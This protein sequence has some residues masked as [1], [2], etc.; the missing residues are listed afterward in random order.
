M[1]R[2]IAKTTDQR[3]KALAKAAT[4]AR[5][6]SKTTL[7][8]VNLADL[9]AERLAAILM[10]LSV[11]THVK[12]VLKLELLAEVG[13]EGLAVEIAKR[14][15]AIGKAT[16]RI[17]WRKRA[18][19][20]RDL[21]LHREMIVRLADGDPKRA[22]GLLLDL[23]DLAETVLD[24]ISQ[25]DGVIGE[26]FFQACEDL[27]PIAAA[28]KLPPG[29]LAERV[30]R[31]ISNDDSAIFESLISIVA[32]GLQA[33]GLVILRDK[34]QAALASRP[35]AG[36]SA[37]DYKATNLRRAILRLADL[38]GDVDAYI[39]SFSAAE[40]RLPSVGAA[41]AMRLLAASR[42]VEALAALE[43]ATP[44]SSSGPNLAENILVEGE[45]IAPN[46]HWTDVY[47]DALQANGRQEEA[48]KAR[49]ADFRATLS[50]VRLRAF[51]KGLPDFDD[52]VAEDEAI[53]LAVKFP[54]FHTA[55]DFLAG[56]PNLV[57]A[58]RL[59]IE[60][61]GEIRGADH[62]LLDPVAR[63]LEGSYPLAATLLLR[64][65]IRNVLTYGIAGRYKAAAKHLL[66]MESLAPT[67]ADFGE[68]QEHDAFL[69]DLR[70]AHGRKQG[71]RSE[72]EAL[73]GI[74]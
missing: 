6:G 21:D 12:R 69:S 45:W 48:Q 30:F 46:D 56:W 5:K 8:Q 71:F 27:G 65:M 11:D 1:A 4:K 52:V 41:V 68:F 42:P 18:A 19:F 44:S 58:S 55:L 25:T 74:F 60:R 20:A 9:G 17:H 15:A 2:A 24:R 37:Y 61:H 49:W 13:P 64:A 54:N 63:R 16:S 3:A 40:K 34:L 39:N 23:L 72:L 43:V 10:D 53:A 22:L 66:E 14:L 57:A 32:T 47:L 51:L 70:A 67:I 36:K 38:T 50:T 73:G 59:I 7:S 28:A 26:V 29:D 31:L 35:R 33:S 62:L